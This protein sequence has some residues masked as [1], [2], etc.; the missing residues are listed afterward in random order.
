M[1]KETNTDTWQWTVR[2]N[3][4]FTFKGYWDI[5]RRKFQIWPYYSLFPN[6]C[7]K[8]AMCLAR[9]LHGKLLTIHFLK[10]LGIIHE[11]NCVFCM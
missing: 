5:V 3:G 8:M 7:P 10:G 1:H 9:A 2:N 4:V 11:D 6:N